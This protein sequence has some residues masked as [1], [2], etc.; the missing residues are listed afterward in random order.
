MSDT[1]IVTEWD[2][3]SDVGKLFVV[4]VTAKM[5]E[6]I[7]DISGD[8]DDDEL[9]DEGNE[10][11]NKAWET[12]ESVVN[13]DDDDLNDNEEEVLDEAVLEID[14]GTNLSSIK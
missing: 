4:D 7:I 9:D 3:M 6:K 13:D 10:M 12:V 1:E 2:E 5:S 8:A 11:D 14:F